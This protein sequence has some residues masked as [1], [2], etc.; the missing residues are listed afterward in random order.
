MVTASIEAYYKVET[1]YPPRATRFFLFPFV[2]FPF[3]HA[4]VSP[5][6]L[7]PF[8]FPSIAAISVSVS[9]FRFRSTLFHVVPPS[10]RSQSFFSFFFLSHYFPLAAFSSISLCSSFPDFADLTSFTLVHSSYSTSVRYVFFCFLTTTFSFSSFFLRN[11]NALV[12]LTE[13]YILLSSRIG[14][15]RARS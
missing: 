8:P 15:Y 4:R 2:S 10:L 13:M 11:K 1:N 7:F 3:L 14:G 12:D 6:F 5:P 9:R